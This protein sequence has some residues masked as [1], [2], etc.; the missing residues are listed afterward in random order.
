MKP[1]TKAQKL[2]AAR[3]SQLGCLVCANNGWP[4]TPAEIHHLF[5]G[6]RVRKHEDIIPLC[7]WHHRNGQY[8]TA[9]H[10]GR[11]E[12]ERLYG[13]QDQLLEQVKELLK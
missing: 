2:H 9:I 5:G 6:G 8:G 7:D 1:M 10:A 11:K 12:W 13:T 3:V 4:D